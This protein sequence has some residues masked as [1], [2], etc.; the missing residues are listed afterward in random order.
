M[1]HRSRNVN[2]CL[3]GVLKREKNEQRGEIFQGIMIENFSELKQVE[4]LIQCL[5]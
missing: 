2:M 5:I 3:I 4:R 1:M